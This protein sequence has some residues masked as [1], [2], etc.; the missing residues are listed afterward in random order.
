MPERLA[1]KGFPSS[2]RLYS[3]T[4]INIG[5]RKWGAPKARKRGAD[6][7]AD[8]PAFVYLIRKARDRRIKVGISGN[9]ERRAEHL[10][11][12]LVRAWQVV[13]EA[14]A[15]VEFEALTIL[16]VEDGEWL[17]GTEA[18]AI[19]AVERAIAA[20]ARRRHVDPAITADEARRQR[21]ALAA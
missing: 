7:P 17:L 4:Y 5:K 15:D 21:I 13:P 18:E 12:K 2:P 11:S 1:P 14:A 16:R 10:Q 20:V 9:P 8:Q 6:L 3:G 19:A